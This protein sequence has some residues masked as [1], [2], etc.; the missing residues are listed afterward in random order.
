MKQFATDV[1]D[2]AEEMANRVAAQQKKPGYAFSSYF[3]TCESKAV[4]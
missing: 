4:F 1:T 3:T 2:S